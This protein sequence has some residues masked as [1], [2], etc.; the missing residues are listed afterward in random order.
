[1]LSVYS[2]HSKMEFYFT[3]LF[4]IENSGWNR[5]RSCRRRW[6]NQPTFLVREIKYRLIMKERI[7]NNFSYG[8]SQ[9]WVVDLKVC[10]NLSYLFCYSRP[11]SKDKLAWEK[12]QTLFFL[13]VYRDLWIFERILF[14]SLFCVQRLSCTWVYV[15]FSLYM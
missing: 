15:P 7:S 9:W 8:Q 4:Y 2:R 3:K 11:Y 13:I 12:N 6:T 1:M 10:Q 14:R 5:N